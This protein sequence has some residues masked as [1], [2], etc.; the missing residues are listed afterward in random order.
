M[1]AIGTERYDRPAGNGYDPGQY[2]PDN[3]GLV[4]VYQYLNDTWNQ[5]HEDILGDT[6]QG[7]AGYVSL[8][9]DGNLL[10]LGAPGAVATKKDVLASINF[11][12]Y[13]YPAP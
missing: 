4:R 2:G 10:A 11:H 7:E 9:G 3:E 5:I 13:R 1:I 6:R 12:Q 8:S